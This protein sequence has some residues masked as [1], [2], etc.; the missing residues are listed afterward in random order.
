[1]SGS[2]PKDN[3]VMCTQCRNDML[4]SRRI[5]SPQYANMLPGTFTGNTFVC[6][7]CKRMRTYMRP[8]CARA[9]PHRRHLE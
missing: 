6:Y 2:D 9:L 5:R 1:M 8:R 4:R 7:T 3:T